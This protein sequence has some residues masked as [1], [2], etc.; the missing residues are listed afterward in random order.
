MRLNRNRSGL[1]LG[2]VV[3]LI[4]GLFG[5]SPAQ[6][7][8]ESAPV[9]T[10]TVGTGYSIL[11]TD[12]FEL[13]TRLGSGQAG[14]G[15]WSYYIVTSTTSA[16]LVV[17]MGTT[18]S[19]YTNT[20]IN[21][22]SGLIGY[23]ETTAGQKYLKLSLANKTSVSEEVTVT[24]TPYQDTDGTDTKTNAD[25]VGD[26]VT[27]TFKPWSALGAVVTLDT[28]Y[29]L[30]QGATASVTVTA[31]SFNFEQFDSNLTLRI[32]HTAEATGTASTA[33]TVTP[34]QWV[35][36]NYSKSGSVTTGIFTTSSVVE[37]VSA[38]IEYGGASASTQVT[39]AVSAR[40]IADVTISA[41]TGANAKQTSAGADARVNSAFQLNAYPHTN[42]IT[43]SMAVAGTFSVSAIGSTFDMDADSGVIINGVTY[44][45][46][47]VLLAKVFTQPAGTTTIDVSTFGQD[48]PDGNTSMD[49]KFSSQLATATV[50]VLFKV[51]T[52]TVAYTPTNTAG[53]AGTAKSFTLSV[54]DNWAQLSSRTDQRV[55]ASVVLGASTSDTVS[56]VV[57]A[58]SATVAVT[59]V[60]AARTGSATV[61]FTLQTF[62]QNTQGWDNTATDTATWNVY[63]S[64]DG[65]VSR[66]ATTSTSVSYGVNLSYSSKVI[67][68]TV[69]N[70]YSDVVASAPGLIIADGDD[71]TSTASGT[72]TVQATNK[73]ANFKFAGTVAGTYVVTFTSGTET[74]TSEVVIAPAASDVG[75][76]IVWD[77]TQITPGKTKVITGTVL[78]ANGNPVDTTGAG[79]EV[80]D[81]GTA[82]ILV[83]Y[84]GDAGII[85]GSMPTETDA[86]G[87]FRLSV[88]T[89]A[90]DKG[91]LTITA[92]YLKDGASTAT[93]D[94][95]TSIN[96]VNVG[97]VAASSEQVVT[98]GTFKGFVA[99]YTRGYMGQKLSAKVAGKWL[100]VDEL[101]PWNG[102]DYSRVV[103]L[104]G[105]GYTINVELYID[106]EYLRTDTVT[107]R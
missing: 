23:K 57:A 86:D 58:G 72:L 78:D 81:S 6:A 32:L 60:P 5:V 18:T 45:Q 62:N 91:T 35:T 39:K 77:T 46:S 41:K 101:E 90:A 51:P 89:S 66:T 103:R 99:I 20:L 24:V 8:N 19:S 71:A 55:A 12:G 61:T 38:H 13:S 44:T 93:A 73:V 54:K 1:A 76:S 26:S 2:A 37:S 94:K 52:Y 7:A 92:T 84:Y 80:G 106:G 30:D 64:A 25:I 98:V 96:A 69:N 28:P 59:P 34:A 68:V 29:A 95:V 11:I 10:P 105:A 87:K 70:S 50:Q 47:A 75:A 36:N 107:T 3:A 16:D 4:A 79:E 97:P 17:G 56:S 85:V 88:L 43:T 83:T 33:A 49:F 63:E 31:G 21:T 14:S 9:I 74:T 104:T 53:P 82:S 27:V 48:T 42:S 22:V 40:T 102:K 15:T 65:L 100:K 67:A